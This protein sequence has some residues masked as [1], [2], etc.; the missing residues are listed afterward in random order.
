MA[1]DLFPLVAAGACDDWLAA[2]ARTLTSCWA[3]L[4]GGTF[5]DLGRRSAPVRTLRRSERRNRAWLCCTMEGRGGMCCREEAGARRRARSRPTK[6][7]SSSVRAGRGR[8]GT[9][10]S[11]WLARRIRPACF[12][13]RTVR[14]AT[15]TL[16]ASTRTGRAVERSH[17]RDAHL[18]IPS[19]ALRL[20]FCMT[21]GRTSVV[22][23]TTAVSNL[24]T[25]TAA[26]DRA[27]RHRRRRRRRHSGGGSR[28]L[29]LG[30]CAT[31]RCSS[32]LLMG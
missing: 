13:A 26:C 19:C 4:R 1:A 25:R 20:T 24:A 6:W 28:I 23:G 7:A 29:R 2:D 16:A 8:N 30:R 11:G 31:S 5:G 21:E 14:A 27:T 17:G 32:L 18:S 3:G 22:A 15:S 10:A 9:A 12:S